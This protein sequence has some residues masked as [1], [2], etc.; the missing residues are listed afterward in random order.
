MQW[1]P[2][3]SLEKADEFRSLINQRLQKL[4]QKMEALDIKLVQ[5]MQGEIKKKQALHVYMH[6]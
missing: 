5:K 6:T 4:R 3:S 1:L 2:L